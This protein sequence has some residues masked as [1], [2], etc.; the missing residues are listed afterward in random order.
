MRVRLLYLIMVRVFGWLVLL[1]RS[2]APSADHPQMGLPEP[3]RPAAHQPRHPRSGAA[4]GAGESG[5]G[6]PQG[7][8]RAM[9][10]RPPHQRGDSTADPAHL[11]VQG[12]P[13]ED[14][15]LLAGVPAHSS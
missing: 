1:G 3:A 4:A 13:A 12:R 9:P 2:Q 15:H 8:R 11:A 10:D 6:I 7:P 5:L 14:G